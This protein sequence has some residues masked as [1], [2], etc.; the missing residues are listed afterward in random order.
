MTEEEL[1]IDIKKLKEEDRLFLLNRNLNEII[2]THQ[3]AMFNTTITLS[4]LALAIS[5]FSVVYQS[6]ILVLVWIYCIFSGIGLLVYITKYKKAQES[7]V[8]KI[9]KLKLNHD[10]LFRHHF[11]YANN[12]E[13]KRK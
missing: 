9:L 3:G 11:A 10:D 12:E 4:L 1:P 6:K 7:L 8:S 2:S 13:N 5:C